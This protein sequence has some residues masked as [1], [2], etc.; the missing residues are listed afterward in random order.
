MTAK[1]MVYKC[2]NRL[3]FPY[4]RTN[5]ISHTA[6]HELKK[7]S[8]NQNGRRH[9]KPRNKHDKS[10]H[11]IKPEMDTV[12]EVTE[13]DEAVVDV[14]LNSGQPTKNNKVEEFGKENPGYSSKD[15]SNDGI[16][17]RGRNDGIHITS[18]DEHLIVNNQYISTLPLPSD[19][20][21][22]FHMNNL[23]KNIS[24]KGRGEARDPADWQSFSISLEDTSPE[25]KDVVI[26]IKEQ[27]EE[28]PPPYDKLDKLNN[29][30]Y[31]K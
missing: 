2:W 29:R 1:H 27:W 8:R 12:P 22:L 13:Q 4:R 3:F 17:T 9:K 30:Q 5:A 15:D 18:D 26:G 7:V 28:G 23:S 19:T 25:N 14:R 20:P 24:Q 21:V 11:S 6:S 10:G 31:K 16:D